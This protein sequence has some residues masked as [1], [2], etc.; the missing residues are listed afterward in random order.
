MLH[1]IL[2]SNS[3]LSNTLLPKRIC[4]AYNLLSACILNK[5]KRI[6][7]SLFRPDLILECSKSGSTEV[8]YYT[9]SKSSSSWS[10][11]QWKQSRQTRQYSA[12][13]PAA[14]SLRKDVIRYEWKEKNAIK[15]VQKLLQHHHRVKGKTKQFLIK[16]LALQPKSLAGKNVRNP[17]ITTS[18]GFLFQLLSAVLQR[19]S[20]EAW[21]WISFLQTIES[22]W[23][24]APIMQINLH[25]SVRFKSRSSIEAFS[26]EFCA[27]L[28]FLARRRFFT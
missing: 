17:W 6:T 2:C 1:L 22:A 15:V 28:L 25:P 12:G 4:L 13:I 18:N 5:Q 8:Q 16:A 24:C 14:W 19:R 9:K 27:N 3:P 21:I 26:W 23:H 11:W 20:N 7:N 10:R